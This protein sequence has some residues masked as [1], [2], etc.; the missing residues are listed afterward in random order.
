MV[1]LFG[2]FPL[3]ARSLVGWTMKEKLPRRGG[4]NIVKFITRHR[5]DSYA[6]AARWF[7]RRDDDERELDG[8]FIGSLVDL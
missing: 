7:L 2:F 5:G 8:T 3:A 4:R 1:S 6:F